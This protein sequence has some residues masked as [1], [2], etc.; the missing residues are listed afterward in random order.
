MRVRQLPWRL[1]A[2]QLAQPVHIAPYLLAR[3]LRGVP[4]PE[5]A[6]IAVYRR[7]NA[8]TIARLLG[9]LPEAE[10]ALWALDEPS[11]SLERHTI[12][13]GGGTRPELLNRHQ[14]A[15][16]GGSRHLLVADDDVRMPA[17]RLRLFLR[18]CAA[19]G[20]DLAQPAHLP[21]SYT[22]WPFVRQRLFTYVRLT[23]FVEQGPMILFSARGV[24]ECFP[25]PED[26]GM[27]WGL[28]A[29]WTRLARDGRRLGI[30]DAAGMRHLSPVSEGYDRGEQESSGRDALREAGFSSYADLQV[31][32]SEW[33]VGR[34]A[35]G[36]VGARR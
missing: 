32:R 31:T 2:R 17:R 7:R 8:P 15:V 13:T 27:G 16:G 29:L 20:L 35:P 1:A 25:L 36:W 28:E 34:P 9:E 18:A 19:A 4:D 3:R 33:R 12:G 26:L 11:E 14:R 21:R 22:S 30:V 24:A 23:D 10:A 5:L 6:V